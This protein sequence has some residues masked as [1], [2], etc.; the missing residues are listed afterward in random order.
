MGWHEEMTQTIALYVV[1]HGALVR[2]DCVRSDGRGSYSMWEDYGEDAFASQHVAGCGIRQCSYADKDWYE[3]DGTF[4]EPPWGLRHG[5]DVA[6]TCECGL[7]ENRAWR[8]TGGLADLI[9]AVTS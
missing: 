8:Y 4:A 6:V 1:E 5:T 9:K 7:I 2:E 3:F